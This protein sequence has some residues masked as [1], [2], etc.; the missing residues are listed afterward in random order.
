MDNA[1]KTSKDLLLRSSGK[2]ELQSNRVNLWPY[3]ALYQEEDEGEESSTHQKSDYSLQGRSSGA[4]AGLGRICQVKVG[5]T[6]S[7]CLEREGDVFTLTEVRDKSQARFLKKRRRK[8]K[9]F[10]RFRGTLCPGKAFEHLVLMKADTFAWTTTS[11]EDFFWRASQ[12]GDCR[13]R[14]KRE[15]SGIL[16]ALLFLAVFSSNS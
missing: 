2:P 4:A 1:C 15:D 16:A 13:W 10:A 12:L 11:R 8:R 5:V 3:V 6:S 7:N 9:G 14:C